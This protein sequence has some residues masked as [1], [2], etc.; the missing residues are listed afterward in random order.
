MEIEGNSIKRIPKYLGKYPS[1]YLS[2]NRYYTFKIR[3]LKDKKLN[4]AQTKTSGDNS[5]AVFLF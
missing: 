2:R 4:T 5:C 1:I 3:I